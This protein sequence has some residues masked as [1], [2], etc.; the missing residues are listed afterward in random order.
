MKSAQRTFWQSSVRVWIKNKQFWRLVELDANLHVHVVTR[1]IISSAPSWFSNQ[2]PLLYLGGNQTFNTHIIKSILTV[3]T[4]PEVSL[5]FN[6]CCVNSH[7]YISQ[8]LICQTVP[9]KSDKIRLQCVRHTIKW[10]SSVL[11]V[12]AKFFPTLWFSINVPSNMPSNI[13]DKIK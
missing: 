1:I 12:K 5:C 2:T 3:G 10:Q 9:T 8:T 11:G 4:K 7:C 13:I 6:I